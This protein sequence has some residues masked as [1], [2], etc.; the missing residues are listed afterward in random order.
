MV[1]NRPREGIE[2]HVEPKVDHVAK[3]YPGFRMYSVLI[4]TRLGYSPAGNR[5][6]MRAKGSCSRYG[7]SG[8]RLRRSAKNVTQF[9]TGDE[10]LG[11]CDGSFAE[12]AF[13]PRDMVA[14]KPADLTVEH[15]AVPTQPSLSQALRG[16][17]TSSQASGS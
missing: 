14:R 1:E 4:S 8:E 11:T 15:A 10:V 9:Q 5:C 13:A 12:Y 7:C 6:I 3:S 2:D 17:G 16:A